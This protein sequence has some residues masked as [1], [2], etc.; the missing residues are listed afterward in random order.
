MG[1]ILRLIAV[2]GVMLVAATSAAL[3]WG[4]DWL[5]TPGPLAEAK[6]IVID[7][8][9][10]PGAIGRQLADAGIITHG[11]AFAPA[12]WATRL[13]GDL[14]AGEYAFP[15]AVSPQGVLDLL[16]SGKTVV[17]YLL[18]PEG[19]TTAEVLA[20]V[21]HGEA[22][23]GEVGESPGEGR[24]WP[25]KYRYS[26]GDKRQALVEDM[27][28]LAA[29]NLAELW[30]TRDPD[31]PLDRPEDAVTLAS[32]VEKETAI[33]AERAKVAAVLY[34]RIRLGMKLQMDPTVAY[35]VT[36]GQH[37]L[38]HP[39]TRA[40]LALESPYNTYLVTGLPPGP[41]ANPGK[42]SLEAVLKPEHS[43]LLY[44]VAD[45]SGGHA[46]AATLE[47]HNRNVAHWRQVQA[48]RAGAGK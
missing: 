4:S 30:A 23:T 1:R 15:A 12:F 24:L 28:K 47:E 5:A 14:R 46:F 9:T 40:E 35:A 3:W 34:N 32:I 33:P 43:D 26:Y 48:E 6:T 7:K 17:H 41:I 39:L 38:D 10:K 21:A 20:L 37:P 45:G 8:G 27:Q 25:A 36:Q 16:R 29:K 44:F 18:V 31:L 2:I 13:D 19:L 42:A 11:A 22:L